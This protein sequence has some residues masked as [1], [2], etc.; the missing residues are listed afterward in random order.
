MT[1]TPGPARPYTHTATVH[2]VQLTEDAD[3]PAIATWC[4]GEIENIGSDQVIRDIGP[5]GI[6]AYEGW[7]IIGGVTG[8][9]FAVDEDDFAE[10]YAPAIVGETVTGPAVEMVSHRAACRQIRDFASWCDCNA[11]AA[12]DPPDG[13]M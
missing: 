5:A 11:L 12:A 3:W 4:G 1:T 10:L 13:G 9:F 2:A 7:W 6:S 8:Q